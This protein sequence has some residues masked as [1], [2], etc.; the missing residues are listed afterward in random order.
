VWFSVSLIPH[1]RSEMWGTQIL[2]LKSNGETWATWRAHKP[3]SILP[4]IANN[5]MNGAQRAE[6]SCTPA[7]EIKEMEL[8]HW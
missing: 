1:L 6:F 8:P 5:A 3:R 4:L 2:R 7:S